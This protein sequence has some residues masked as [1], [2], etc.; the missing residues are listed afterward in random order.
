MH[1]NKWKKPVWKSSI[2][3]DSNYMTFWKR[4]NYEDSGKFS[5]WQE[6]QETMGDDSREFLE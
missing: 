6:F 5:S 4:Q 2:L 1:V 3:Y